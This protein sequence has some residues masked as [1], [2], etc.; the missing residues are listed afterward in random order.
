[1]FNF[2]PGAGSK[3]LD[4]DTRKAIIATVLDAANREFMLL[5]RLPSPEQHAQVQARV[6]DLVHAELRKFTLTTETPVIEALVTDILR[7]L[8]GLGFLDAL[9]PPVRT[10]LSEI[11]IYST[12]LFQVMRKDRK[13][14]V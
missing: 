5:L 14:V 3:T 12:G 1:M 9:L 6:T 11:A 7:R 10:D 4:D 13:S 2:V 8:T